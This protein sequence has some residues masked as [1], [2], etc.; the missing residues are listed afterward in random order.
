MVV[1]KLD[2]LSRDVAFVAGL[3]AQPV[4]FIVAELGRDADP[5]ML[6]L[7]AALAE[8]DRRV[9]SER[10][11]AA[12]A[13]KKGTGT[14]GNPTNLA[15][16]GASGRASST[17]AADQFARRV[18]PVLHSVRVEGAVMPRAMA[19]RTHS[20]AFFA[21]ITP[22]ERAGRRRKYPSAQV[23]HRTGPSVTRS[24]LCASLAQN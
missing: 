3:M 7:Y 12:L 11:K 2:R 15:L 9:I 1:A 17:A 13:S 16:A 20:S 4:P 5:F 22:A 14:L 6:H 23:R 24:K 18:A 21:A 10:T 19:G 8:Q